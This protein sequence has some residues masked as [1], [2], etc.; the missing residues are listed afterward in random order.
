MVGFG[1]QSIDYDNDSDLDLVVTNGHLD[2][3]F[4]NVSSFRQPPQLLCNLGGH[5]QLTEVKDAS[6]YWNSDHLGRGLAR[7]DF[8]RDGKSDFVIT[9]IGEQSALLLNQ[10]PTDHHWLQL[11][12]VGTKSERDSIGARIRIRFG[13]QESTDWVV[14]GDGYL[15][16]NEAVVSFGLGE[17]ASVDEIAIFWPSGDQQTIQNVPADRRLLIIEG[18]NDPYALNSVP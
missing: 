1:T 3:S 17:A 6:D 5:F 15:S 9:H 13:G 18:Q 16:H 2:D 11:Q 10:T 14:A 8:N 12:L 4:D 7:L